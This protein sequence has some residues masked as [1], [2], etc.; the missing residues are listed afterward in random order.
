MEFRFDAQQEYQIKAIESIATLFDG[1]GKIESGIRYA[2][3]VGF[4][5]FP[6]RLDLGEGDILAN[7]KE[8]QSSNNIEPTSKLEYIEKEIDTAE[9]RRVSR[10][11]NFSVEMETGTGKT[12]VYIRTALELHKRYGFRRFI[13]VVP[14]I[15]IKEGVLKTFEITR[16]HFEE[17]YDNLPYKFYPYDSSNL[18][19]VR[20]FASSSSVEFMIMTL[21]SFNKSMTVEN[22][23]NV[24]RRPT[25]R[26]QGITPIHLVQASRPILILDEPQNMESEKS[27]AALATLNP[28]FALRY[29]ATHRNPYNLVYRLGPAGAYRQGLVKKIEVASVLKEDDVNQAFIRVEKITS[30]KHTIKAK[31]T[32]NKL[33]KPGTVKQVSVTVKPDENLFD[34]T[35]LPDYKSFVVNEIHPGRHVVVFGN[36]VEIREGEAQG[37]DKEAIFEAQ[38]R[39]TIEEHLQKQKDLRDKGIKVLSLFFIDRVAN[40]ESDDGI[41]K[42]AFDKAFTELTKKHAEWKSL[43]PDEVRERYFA[44]MRRKGGEQVYEDSTSGESQKDEEAY[45]LIM[46]DKEKLLSFDS[47]IAFI[48]SHSALREG[49]DNPNVFQICTM[50]QTASEM[51]KRQEVGRGVRLAVNQDGERIYDPDVNRLTVV[52][53]ESYEEY[54]RR[55]QEEIVEE[56]GPGVELPPKP[57]DRR[58]RVTVTKRKEYVLKKEFKELWDKI[59]SKTRYSVV[60]DTEKLLEEALKEIDSKTIRAPK[61]V[62]KKALL[63][64]NDEDVFEAL[65]MSAAKTFVDLAGRY[66]LPNLA[67]IM[68]HLLENTTPPVRLSRKTLVDVFS[69]SKNQKAAIDNPFEF[70]SVASRV[71]KEKLAD[72][73]V[74][75]IQYEKVSEWYEMTQLVDSFETWE[76]YVVPAKKGVYD[77]VEFDSEIEKSFVKGLENNE[78]VRMYIKLPSWFKVKTPVGY[79]NPD[80]AIV[81]EDRDQHGKPNGKPLIYLVRETKD[82]ANLGKLRPDELRKMKCGEKH[83]K[84]A[85]GVDFKVVKSASELP[86]GVSVTS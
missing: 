57:A 11:P 31:L 43:K 34:K 82:T 83:F 69:K 58:K 61:V 45:D 47:K 77:Q 12:Y 38:I 73:L 14:S 15:A 52:A 50:N 72:H 84:G 36:G 71:L 24:I 75:G 20:Q 21:D 67:D 13:I 62:V 40:Y 79:Y 76:N 4:I 1:Q 41:I 74:N 23:G 53:N 42:K 44:F 18:T 27:I 29:S 85:L 9:G 19:Q 66:P 3:N 28:L 70:A 65:S 81:W 7:L 54:V 68:N 6:N 16:R 48:F 2:Q 86:G 33:M 37:A 51:K 55:L 30:E 39:Y 60:I 22:K 35:G 17:L 8:A 63:D 46:R 64:L 56:Y 10:F 5:G 26:L 25:D 59:K 32:V 78:Q 49:W 80:W